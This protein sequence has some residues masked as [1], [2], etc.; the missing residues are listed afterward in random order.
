MFLVT[1]NANSVPT[2][3]LIIDNVVIMLCV[4]LFRD[5]NTPNCYANVYECN[6]LHSIL[7]YVILL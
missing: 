3:L 1:Q 2:Y 4:L 6:R 5:R 7:Q